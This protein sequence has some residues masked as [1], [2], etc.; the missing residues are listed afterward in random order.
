M[1]A[2]FI[3]QHYFRSFQGLSRTVISYFPPL[4]YFSSL[5]SPLVLCLFPRLLVWLRRGLCLCACASVSVSLW[6]PL[7]ANAATSRGEELGV[8]P[9]AL[10][11]RVSA[12]LRRRKRDSKCLSTAQNPIPTSTYPQ[13]Q[14]IKPPSSTHTRGTPLEDHGTSMPSMTIH[15]LLKLFI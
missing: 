11:L 12:C 3:L 15:P 6:R 4:T 10:R 2:S 7:V 13:I 5:L 8:L 1:E 14:Y 9:S